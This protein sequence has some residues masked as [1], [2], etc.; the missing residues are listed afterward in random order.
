MLY[1]TIKLMNY[2]EYTP[3]LDYYTNPTELGWTP[4]QHWLYVT[5]NLNIALVEPGCLPHPEW[6]HGAV[7]R[8]WRACPRHL[9]AN[10][11]HP[12]HTTI[13]KVKYS[14]HTNKVT[15]IGT[16]F[17]FS[18]QKPLRSSLSLVHCNWNSDSS[19][20]SVGIQTESS[21]MR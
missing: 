3:C 11:P 1:Q 20:I 17:N 4:H 13:T 12:L 15:H 18:K 2:S 8:K 19:F 9:A 21:G 7:G 5:Y 14:I 16:V 10:W 6:N